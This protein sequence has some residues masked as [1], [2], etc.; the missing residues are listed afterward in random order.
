MIRLFERRAP[1]SLCTSQRSCLIITFIAVLIVALAPYRGQAQR[2]S[3]NASESEATSLVRDLLTQA[4]LPP[5]KIL[6]G[7]YPLLGYQDHTSALLP[8][9]SFPCPLL[10][11]CDAFIAQLKSLLLTRGY[12]LVYSDES[13]RPGGPIHFAIARGHTPVMALRLYPAHTSIT[14]VLHMTA[15][16]I[17]HQAILRS[18]SPH[19]TFAFSA[20]VLNTS[21][22]FVQ[23][24]IEQDRE[25][26]IT[27][28]EMMVKSALFDF[29]SGSVI[30]EAATRRSQL[31]RQIKRLFDALPSALGIYLGRRA[32]D[33]LDRA[34]ID[35]LVE[36]CALQYRVIV[37]ARHHD[38]ILPSVARAHGVRYVALEH[39]LQSA[40]SQQ[41]LKNQLKAFEATLV[42]NGEL[43]LDVNVDSASKLLDVSR[44]IRQAVQRQVSVL[45]ISEIAR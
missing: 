11:S 33:A 9:L 30:R 13:P 38:D 39:Q 32:Q 41:I 14:S 23:Q 19:L 44:W 22:R 12:Q 43:R 6:R 4:E 10:L 21:P 28:D 27:I 20:E 17:Q 31:G 36:Q 40:M 2:W 7:S 8:L 35:E 15:K 18:L 26:L 5:E 1:L 34:A 25:H 24:L 3:A 16:T 45:R 37:A 42:L 29:E